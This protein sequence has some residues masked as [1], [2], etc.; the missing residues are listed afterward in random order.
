VVGAKESGEAARRPQ[1]ELDRDRSLYLQSAFGIGIEACSI[2]DQAAG[3]G[4]FNRNK[5][6]IWELKPHGTTAHITPISGRSWC[7]SSRY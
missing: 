1:N 6:A 3:S 7:G 4:E 5:H 2:A